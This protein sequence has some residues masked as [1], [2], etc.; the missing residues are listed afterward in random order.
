MSDGDITERQADS[1]KH[2]PNTNASQRRLSNKDLSV[3]IKSVNATIRAEEDGY[4]T[5]REIEESRFI[6]IKRQC[7]PAAASRSQIMI[8]SR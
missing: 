1:L 8:M 5:R 3:C 2:R 6:N 4:R 7:S